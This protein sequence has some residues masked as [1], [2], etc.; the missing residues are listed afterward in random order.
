MDIYDW[1]GLAALLAYL[2]VLAALFAS[3][4]WAYRTCKEVQQLRQLIEIELRKQRKA[5]TGTGERHKTQGAKPV[6][7]SAIGAE[8]PASVNL[9]S[10]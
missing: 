9:R 4:Y 5:G 10:R 7:D 2:F 1:I 8:R 6:T 3:Q